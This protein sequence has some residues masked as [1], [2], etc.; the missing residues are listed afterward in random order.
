MDPKACMDRI[1]RAM[2]RGD[3][4]EVRDACE[5]L[6]GWISKGGFVPEGAEDLLEGASDWVEVSR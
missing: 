5:D 4:E 6:R 3:L 2:D 1:R